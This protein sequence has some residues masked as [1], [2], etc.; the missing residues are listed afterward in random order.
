[1]PVT[2][3]SAIANGYQPG[4]TRKWKVRRR[5]AR[6]PA[7]PLGEGRR[8]ERGA[9]ERHRREE[10]ER[11]DARQLEVDDPDAIGRGQWHGEDRG[12]SGVGDREED[13]ERVPSSDG[14]HVVYPFRG[15]DPSGS[16]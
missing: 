3:S 7:R 12:A 14:T 11:R 4:L 13:G 9:G 10:D 6:T 15:H 1:M 16:R 8:D 2:G 5:K